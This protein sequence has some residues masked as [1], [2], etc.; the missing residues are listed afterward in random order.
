MPDRLDEPIDSPCLLHYRFATRPAPL[1]V[2]TEAVASAGMIDICVS[3]PAGQ[4]VY[5]RT[6]AI[7]VPCGLTE[8][9][10]SAHR[11][12]LN[13]VPDSKWWSASSTTRATAPEL[14]LDP[15]A[16]Y[17]YF[18]ANCSYASAQ[19][20]ID[21]QLAFRLFTKAVNPSQGTFHL[22]ISELS[23]ADPSTLSWRSSTFAL[24]KSPVRLYL[25]NFLSRP[26]PT[27]KSALP[28]TEFQAGQDI[29]LQS[30]SNG[31]TFAL[32]QGCL[33]APVWT[34]DDTFRTLAGGVTA[35]TTFTLRAELTADGTDHVA[36]ATMTVTVPDPLAATSATEATATLTVA[37]SSDLAGAASF[38]PAAGGGQL[39]V[40][41]AAL[42]KDVTAA[43]IAATGRVCLT[44]AT[45][46]NATVK[47]TAKADYL[48]PAS[49]TIGD[50]TITSDLWALGPTAPFPVVP[51]KTYV[52]SSDGFLVGAVPPG[53][54]C[55]TISG[56]CSLIGPVYAMGGQVYIAPN[57]VT[58]CPNT[59]MLPVPMG[60]PFQATIVQ[61]AGAGAAPSFGWFPL[62]MSATLQ[63]AE[64]A[65]VDLPA[66]ADGP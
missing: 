34:G 39:T 21:Y 36:W 35:T 46:A 3:A 66:P 41:G 13:V 23:G 57:T 45:M 38:G 25:D 7:A 20:P 65:A 60:A 5:C 63:E 61:S 53:G 4:V 51:G 8:A 15:S 16:T 48:G 59:F 28:Q 33:T 56:S 54:Q 40:A 64:S 22:V 30:E 27:S 55:S 49:A 9:D 18:T 24:R 32:Y 26:S 29:R 50:L 37:G 47:G 12:D 17:A 10:L 6:I 11:S 44:D 62:A 19:R 31:A 2:S 42:L 43:S 1:Q 14:G 52:A 58:D